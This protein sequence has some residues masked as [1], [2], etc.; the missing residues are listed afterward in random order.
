MTR[1]DFIELLNDIEQLGYEK[2]ELIGW[3][4]SYVEVTLEAKELREK[5]VAEYDRL[6]AK[7]EELANLIIGLSG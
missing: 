7:V 3:G 6:T 5:V 4:T 2:A 1:E